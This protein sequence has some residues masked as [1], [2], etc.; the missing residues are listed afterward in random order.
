MKIY[1]EDG[2]LRKSPINHFI[3]IDHIVEAKYGY[4][5]NEKFLDAIKAQYPNDTVYTNQITALDNRYAWNAE[6]KVPEVYIR[7][8]DGVFTRIDELT[9]RE[10]REAHNLMKMY[11]ANE[12]GNFDW[13]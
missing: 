8:K 11:I 6:L 1:F 9:N 13:M 4:Y 7:N 10:L 5:H 12:F 3:D 2:E